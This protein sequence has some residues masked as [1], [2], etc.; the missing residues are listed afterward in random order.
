MTPIIN[1]WW[2]Y[3]IDMLVSVDFIV[4]FVAAC[5]A[6]AFAILTIGF[7]CCEDYKKEALK[8]FNKYA[9]LSLIVT[10]IALVVVTIIPSKKTIYTMMVLDNVTQN[11]VELVKGS[12]TNTIDYLTDKIEE[13]VDG[14]KEET[15]E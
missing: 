3:F 4:C 14:E 10:I 8:K 2:I 5:G 1:P 13:I 7:F 9:K 12:I 6:P 15:N 11:N